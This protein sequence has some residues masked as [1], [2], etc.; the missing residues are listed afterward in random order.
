VVGYLLDHSALD[1]RMQ[2][3]KVEVVD[4][5]PPIL[6]FPRHLVVLFFC[7]STENF[8]FRTF[9]FCFDCFGFW[10]TGYILPRRQWS[11]QDKFIHFVFI[12]THLRR[13]RY[14]GGGGGAR[15]KS[16][17]TAS[18]WM[19]LSF[20]LRYPPAMDVQYVEMYSIGAIRNCV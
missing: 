1:A 14:N 19:V 20:W 18:R 3:D 8:D 16:D 6:L 13:W 17:R 15:Q 5:L 11:I 7:W 2:Y 4:L 10:E 12:E 9:C